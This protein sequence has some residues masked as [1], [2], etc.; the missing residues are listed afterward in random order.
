MINSE[1]YLSMVWP[2]FRL[3]CGLYEKDSSYY[4]ESSFVF[5]ASDL[6][7]IFFITDFV[8]LEDEQ[9]QAGSSSS[10]SF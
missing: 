1:R 2:R 7:N 9:T 8:S 5:E 6:H 4:R 10:L 3:V